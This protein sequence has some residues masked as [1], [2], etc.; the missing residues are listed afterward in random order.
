MHFETTLSAA[1]L[2]LSFSIL[3]SGFCIP[4]MNSRLPMWNR[5]GGQVGLP[6][7]SSRQKNV[8]TRSG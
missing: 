6:F 4:E 7:D 2:A 1:G 5:V 8:G 3:T